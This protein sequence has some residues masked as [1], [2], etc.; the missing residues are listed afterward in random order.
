M[1][2]DAFQIERAPILFEAPMEVQ[3]ASGTVEKL[4]M[5]LSYTKEQ[6]KSV[7]LT[8]AWGNLQLSAPIEVAV[9]N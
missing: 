5:T 2:L 3:K 6:M 1:H 9:G 8:I 4:T 7:K